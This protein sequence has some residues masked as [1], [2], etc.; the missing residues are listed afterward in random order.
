M[1]GAAITSDAG[2]DNTYG[3]GDVIRVRLTFSEAV[4]VTGA[5]R[6]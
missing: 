3:L 1:T 4:T 5:P 6:L 2:D